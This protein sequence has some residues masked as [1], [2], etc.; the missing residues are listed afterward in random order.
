M[1]R[2]IYPIVSEPIPQLPATDEL[3]WREPLSEPTNSFAQ[4]VA[5]AALITSLAGG[6]FTVVSPA[7]QNVSWAA[8]Q[9]VQ[10][11]PAR[12][13]VYGETYVPAI[14]EKPA[15]VQSADVT[16]VFN[17]RRISQT[18]AWSTFTP[19]VAEV[20]PSDSWYIQ[21][22]DPVRVAPRLEVGSQQDLAFGPRLDFDPKA[23][24]GWYQPL[25]EPIVK[26]FTLA[27]AQQQA[28]AVGLRL[29]FDDASQIGWFRPLDRPT[30][31]AEPAPPHD[32][33]LY[34][35]YDTPPD[36][37][38]VPLD[39]WFRP[40]SEPFFAKQF[41]AADQQALAIGLRL[42]FDDASQIGWYRPFIEPL[43]KVS[44]PVVEQQA[45]AFVPRLDFDPTAQIGWYVPLDEP[46]KTVRPVA[47]QLSLAWG[48]FTPPAEVFDPSTSIA[49]H[50]PLSEPPIRSRPVAFQL[51][52]AWNA[53]E[54]ALVRV[55]T[56]TNILQKPVDF[57]LADQQWQWLKDRFRIF[58]IRPKREHRE[59]R[60]RRS[61]LR[62][63]KGPRPS[64][65]VD[66]N[67]KGHD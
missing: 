54:V 20:P 21:V 52:L 45:L 44:S 50:T 24:I 65:T 26:R 30:L 1:Q 16:V 2:V 58:D 62:K 39:R 14:D 11:T 25:S 41:R 12:I 15:A 36:V 19:T 56:D 47:D 55:I 6:I 37:A 13:E 28:L 23:Q 9:G 67:K 59:I 4:K 10:F 32:A 31:R 64:F 60:G 29:D 57:V 53:G 3:E 8:P 33:F 22:S 63:L 43:V 38:V 17:E 46:L 5:K 66:T 35:A 40:F 18:L 7:E 42:D 51:S 27:T 61:E 34:G 48:V 49:W